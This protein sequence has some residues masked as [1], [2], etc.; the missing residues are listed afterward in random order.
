MARYYDRANTYEEKFNE[1][2]V[3]TIVY[4]KLFRDMVADRVCI[5]RSKSRPSGSEFSCKACIMSIALDRRMC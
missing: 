5:L 2:D 4:C 3:L 1:P